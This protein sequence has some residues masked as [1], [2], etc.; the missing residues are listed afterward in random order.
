[1]DGTEKVTISEWI[2]GNPEEIGKLFDSIARLL[3]TSSGFDKWLR[4]DEIGRLR[5]ENT[6]LKKE[7]EIMNRIQSE[8]RAL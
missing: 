6:M 3:M 2:K 8:K 7:L 4:A 1:M 5:I